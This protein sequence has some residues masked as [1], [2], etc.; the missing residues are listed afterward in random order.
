MNEDHPVDRETLVEEFGEEE[1]EH[2]EWWSEEMDRV[3]SVREEILETVRDRDD[4]QLM[5]TGTSTS[6]DGRHETTFKLRVAG[7]PWNGGDDSDE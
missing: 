6:R 7:E 2:T 1:V 5:K 3:R 4:V